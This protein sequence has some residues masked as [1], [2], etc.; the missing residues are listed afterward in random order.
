MISLTAIAAAAWLEPAPFAPPKVA[1]CSAI[2]PLTCGRRAQVE[3]R[4]CCSSDGFWFEP[5]RSNEIDQSGEVL[6]E[7]DL[8]M[9]W[10][11]L[12]SEPQRWERTKTALLTSRLKR[13]ES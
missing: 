10:R 4:F 13:L 11:W 3:A 6:G 7:I 2:V 8:R 5:V 12:K 1:D 9:T